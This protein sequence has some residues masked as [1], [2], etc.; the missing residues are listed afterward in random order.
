MHSHRRINNDHVWKHIRQSEKLANVTCLYLQHIK[1]L[2]NI[3]NI[4]K[5]LVAGF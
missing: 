2:Y 5:Q 1:Y 4:L 3:R